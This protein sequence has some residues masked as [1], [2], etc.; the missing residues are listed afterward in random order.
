MQTRVAD[1]SMAPAS[2]PL[3]RI[4]MSESR[5]DPIPTYTFIILAYRL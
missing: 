5:T 2:L 4:S 3:A 1:Y